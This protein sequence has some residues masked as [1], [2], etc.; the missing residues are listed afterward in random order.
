MKK[1]L[2]TAVFIAL[3]MFSFY[4]VSNVELAYDAPGPDPMGIVSPN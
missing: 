4:S 2:I 3:L 1:L